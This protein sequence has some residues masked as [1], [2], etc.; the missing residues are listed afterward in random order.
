MNSD[1]RTR[2]GMEPYPIPT[3]ADEGILH[4]MCSMSNKVESEEV[5]YQQWELLLLEHTQEHVIIDKRKKL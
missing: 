4:I 5:H 2:D 1:D 3:L